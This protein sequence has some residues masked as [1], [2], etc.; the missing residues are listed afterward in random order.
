MFIENSLLAD[1]LILALTLLT[2]ASFLAGFVDAVAGGAGLILVP[3]FMLCGM[4]PQLALGQEKLVSSIGTLSAIS[5]FVKDKKVIWK[6]VPIG[7]LLAIIGAYVGA[8]AIL[9]LDEKLVAQIIVVM[10]P[11]G[12][13][14]T[15]FKKKVISYAS[16]QKQ[17]H[18]QLMWI[19]AVVSFT[20][21]FYDGFFGPGTGSLFIIALFLFA[22][23]DLVKASATSKIF[24]L[25]SNIGA[26]VAFILAG[27][28]AFLIG[29]PLIIGSLIGNHTG[30]KL[31]INRGDSVVKSVLVITVLLMLATLVMKFI[32]S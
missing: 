31:A 21:G 3:A 11:I 4:P 2:F 19:I 25:A 16:E 9:F 13:V 6:L 26:F 22:K 24:N 17:Q 28:I 1:N 32:N 20:V 7:L 12:L 14:L 10:L 23:I 29:I 27:K 5:N 30:S 15:L 8:K 18:K